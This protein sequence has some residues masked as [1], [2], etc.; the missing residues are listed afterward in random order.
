[1]VRN[2]FNVLKKLWPSP[3]VVAKILPVLGAVVLALGGYVIGRSAVTRAPAQQPGGPGLYGAPPVSDEYKQRVVAYIHGNISVTRE[4]LGEFL[5]KRLGAERLEMCVHN[6]I[7]E[8]ACRAKGIQVTDQEVEAQ[9][10]L[11]FEQAKKMSHGLTVREFERVFLKQKGRNLVEF[12][13][14]IIRTKLML[15]QLVMPT[16]Q[17]TDEDLRKGYEGRYGPKVEC[18]WIVVKDDHHRFALWE[19]VKRSEAAFAEAATTVNIS[20]L[21]AQGGKMPPIHKHFGDPNIERAAFALKP[22]DVSPL[23]G[24]PDGT[25]AILKCDRLIPEDPTKR[26]ENELPALRTEIFNFKLNQ[27]VEEVRAKLHGDA[28]PKLLLQRQTRQEDLERDVIPEI[29]GA[30]R[31]QKTGG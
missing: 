25:V 4:E 7:I 18:R 21:N 29:S 1:M 2:A 3:R 27:R 6:K 10:Q 28:N 17:V 30:P 13:E 23:V 15:A 14:D 20:P 9:F 16:I 31:P 11:E 8:L 26:F 12:K 19:K 22:G 24:L 5:I